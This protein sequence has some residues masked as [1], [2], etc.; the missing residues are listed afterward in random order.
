MRIM[1]STPKLFAYF[2]GSLHAIGLATALWALSVRSE[3]AVIGPSTNAAPAVAF[4]LRSAIQADNTG[5]FLLDLM[6]AP[7]NLPR[8]RLCDAPA[9]GKTQTLKRSEVAELARTAGFDQ[10]LTNWSGPAVVRISRRSRVLAEKEA[11]QLLTQA[12]QRQFVKE[13]GELELRLTQPLAGIN[14]PDDPFSIK[15]SDLPTSGVSSAFI[16]RFGI[17]TAQGEEVGSWQASLQAKVWRDI[18]VAASALK[19][20]DSV[21]GADLTRQRRDV[22][23]CWEPLAEFTP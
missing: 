8:L 20:G 15:I 3:N 11:L 4:Q 14:V 12:I 21:R 5:V 9:F 13:R 19:R 6:E 1:P 22:L 23:L 10:S 18:W 17:E 2:R 16:V 7:S